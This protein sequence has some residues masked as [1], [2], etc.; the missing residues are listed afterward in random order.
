MS[1]SNHDQNPISTATMVTA[2]AVPDFAAVG[3]AV[4]EVVHAVDILTSSSCQ[5]NGVLG[6]E[7]NEV[8]LKEY[9]ASLNW[10]PG[11]QNLLTQNLRNVPI[12]Y[13]IC[14]DSGSM[15]SSD[16]TRIHGS[17]AASRLLKC[18]RWLELTESL[19]FHVNLARVASAPIEFRMLNGGLPIMIGA[20]GGNDDV[21]VSML[22]KKFSQSPSGATPLCR[23]I[24]EVTAKIS[25]LAPQLIS[26]GQRAV[27]VIATDGESS[28]GNLAETLRLLQG[29][30]VWIVVRLCTNDDR[31]VDY[32]NNIDNEL[33]LDI[34]VLDDFIG[35]AN[36]INALNGFLTYGEP[37]HRIRE[38][39]LSVKEF[40]LLDEARL[41]P[42]QV[43][44]I[45]GTM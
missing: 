1:K 45:C 39:G 19:K 32:W 16:G 4:A 35:E 14:D 2:T 34:D 42:E 25:E 7:V 36:E 5:Q 28:D 17:G 13:I 31:I 43:Q 9:L 21:S 24:R 22:L 29:L 41:S 33:E 3:I 23:H 27:L 15:S 18:T 10:P 26:R 30:P 8:K 12:R 38:L 11:L 37:L 40:D 6:S 44:L 20:T